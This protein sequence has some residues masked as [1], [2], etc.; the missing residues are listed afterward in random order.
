VEVLID[1]SEFLPLAAEEL[2]SATSHVH[3]TGWY[4]TPELAMTRARIR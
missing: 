3:V 1:G 2:A 4:F